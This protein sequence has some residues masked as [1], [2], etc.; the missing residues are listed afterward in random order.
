M[1]R[2]SP[3]PDEISNPA[4]K[5]AVIKEIQNLPPTDNLADILEGDDFDPS[6]I[7]S[8]ARTFMNLPQFGSDGRIVT[9]PSKERPSP[10]SQ[11]PIK[12]TNP[13]NTVLN[14]PK[15]DE[16]GNPT[17]PNESTPTSTTLEM[18][19]IFNENSLEHSEKLSDD[20]KIE[21]FVKAGFEATHHRY[22]P[23]EGTP[24]KEGFKCVI[25]YAPNFKKGSLASEYF[26][27]F[28]GPNE[29]FGNMK[30]PDFSQIPESTK[31]PEVAYTFFIEENGK[32]SKVGTQSDNYID[33]KAP[34]SSIAA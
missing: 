13:D 16:K 17:I 30:R 2:R 31:I 10:E 15:F 22:L 28:L 27:K 21:L 29:K 6:T 4:I 32:L 25:A 5:A 11:G 8:E 24:I 9:T 34:L 12:Q 7:S 33:P 1:E 14:L 18:K 20:V 23:K 19:K 3:R 26:I